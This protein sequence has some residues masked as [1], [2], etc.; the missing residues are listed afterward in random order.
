M[1]RRDWVCVPAAWSRD[2]ATLS[3]SSG[4]EDLLGEV[5]GPQFSKA[6]GVSPWEV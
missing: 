2:R 6:G 1:W 4:A 3:V 5:L